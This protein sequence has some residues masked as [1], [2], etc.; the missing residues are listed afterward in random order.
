MDYKKSN[1]LKKGILINKLNEYNLYQKL[2]DFN[3]DN[4]K[5]Y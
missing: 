4:K 5:E 2:Y 3:T 1:G